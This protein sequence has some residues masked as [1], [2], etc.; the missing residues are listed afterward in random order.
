MDSSSVPFPLSKFSIRVPTHVVIIDW[1]QTAQFWQLGNASEMISFCTFCKIN[2]SPIAF[3]FTSQRKKMILWLMPLGLPQSHM[4]WLVFHA[5][6]GPCDGCRE[7]GLGWDQAA[8]RR[9][10]KNLGLV[11]NDLRGLWFVL[12]LLLF[13]RNWF[14]FQLNF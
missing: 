10:P 12:L 11:R 9:D 7:P 1:G 3:A 4:H 2:T 5:L 14:N 8:K 6:E 13:W